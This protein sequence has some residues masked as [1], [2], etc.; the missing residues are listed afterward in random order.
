MAFII[1]WVR[2]SVVEDFLNH[3]KFAWTYHPDVPLKKIDIAGAAANPS[4]AFLKFDE[5][6]ANGIWMAMIDGV[7]IPPII[8]FD[9]TESLYEIGDGRHRLHNVVDFAKSE[10]IVS[11][12]AIIITNSSPRRRILLD[13][14]LN[15]NQG[16]QIMPEERLALAVQW[17]RDGTVEDVKEAAANVSLSEKDVAHRWKMELMID[18]AIKL[19]VGDVFREKIL[20]RDNKNHDASRAFDAIRNDNAYIAAVK[21]CDRYEITKTQMQ[22]LARA[23][24]D[25][26]TEKKALDAVAGADEEFAEEEALRKA[27]TR[28][29]KSTTRGKTYVG[30]L[31]KAKGLGPVARFGLDGTNS[32]DF[33][34]ILTTLDEIDRKNDEVRRWITRLQEEERKAE[35]SRRAASRGAQPS[36]SA[37]PT[38]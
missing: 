7:G 14:R 38:P 34:G 26:S 1:N 19:G 30:Y 11:V 35:E 32:K 33:I 8:L 12:P 5:K 20:N 6:N 22:G 37:S 4:R 36:G 24:G 2:S 10:G 16:R 17:L 3:E 15:I 9:T 25:A 23:V 21:L 28:G 13:A 27:K 31:N 29:S 18:R